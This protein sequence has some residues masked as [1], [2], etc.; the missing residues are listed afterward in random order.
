MEGLDQKLEGYLDQI[1]QVSSLE[2]LDDVRVAA[3]GKQGEISQMMKSLGKVA[4]EE[5]KEM[6][7]VLNKVRASIQDAITSRKEN[8]EM[9]VLN[10]RLETEKVDV[11]LP[12]LQQSAGRVHPL[13]QVFYEVVDI[14]KNMGFAVASGPHIENGFHNFDALNIPESHPA[15][16]EQD[17]FYLNAKDDKGERLV[18]R[19]HTSP[20]QVRTMLSEKP[21]IKIVSPGRTFRSDSDA[22]HTP[23]FHQIEG[24]VI[25]EGVHMGHLKGCLLDFFRK[26]FDNP[27]LNLRFRSSYFPFTEPSAEVDI[28][29]TRTKDEL[30]VEDGDDWMEILGCGMVHRK[31]LENCNLD[32]DKYQGFAFGMGLER[33]GMLKYGIPDL[34]AFYDA[35]L[36]WLKHHGFS[37]FSNL[38]SNISKAGK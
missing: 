12:V 13:S 32:P 11:T 24:L 9:E 5:R 26:F 36:R 20:V 30:R 14:F 38:T 29:C 34:R 37:S 1:S 15:R 27:N 25:A 8:L 16:E 23:N 7:Q 22:T 31:V 6:G 33:I 17:T 4:P 21:P 18:L 3:L 28:S 10:K 35:D 2:A 19:T